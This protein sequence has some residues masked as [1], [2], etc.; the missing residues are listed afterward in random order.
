MSKSLRFVE[1]LILKTLTIRYRPKII[2]ACRILTSFRYLEA[3]EFVILVPGFNDLFRYISIKLKISPFN[4]FNFY[5]F[6]D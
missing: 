3:G 5:I 6:N 2:N 1:N 4:N